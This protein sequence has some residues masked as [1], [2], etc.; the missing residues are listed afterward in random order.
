[1]TTSCNVNICQKRHAV[2]TGGHSSDCNLEDFLV[3]FQQHRW[4]QTVTEIEPNHNENIT[5]VLLSVKDLLLS[6][7]LGKRNA[8]KQTNKQNN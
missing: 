8:N 5:F 1:M 7:R 2:H 3:Y 6:P 4:T